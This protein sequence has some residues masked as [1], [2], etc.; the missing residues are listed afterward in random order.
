MKL[1]LMWLSAPDGSSESIGVNQP[2]SVEHRKS[3]CPRPTPLDVQLLVVKHFGLEWGLSMARRL[4]ALA[5]VSFLLAGCVVLPPTEQYDGISINRV[6]DRVKC[7]LGAA[8]SEEPILQSW[9]GVITLTL[10]VDH[11]GSVLPSTSL[12]GPFNA[13]TYGLD[14]SAGATGKSVQT[15]LVNVYFPV[16]ELL[17]FAEAC[18][19]APRNQLE[20]S[21]GL[22]EWVTRTL[23]LKTSEGAVFK[24][25]DK[26]IGYT[27]EFDLD[28]TAGITPG[29][30]FSRVSG[31]AGLS[32]NRRTVNTLQIALADAGISPPKRIPSYVR[33]P[34]RPKPGEGQPGEIKPAEVPLTG[35][36][37]KPPA[38]KTYRYE[39]RYVVRGGGNVSDDAKKR[40]DVIIQQLQLRNLRIRGF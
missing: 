16:Y 33:V 4:A 8:L 29:F 17:A 24:D 1:L 39:K 36:E 38:A 2:A 21:L 32:I 5:C 13:G 14:I 40:L 37:P 31:K 18:P 10:E 9:V 34:V 15:S 30:T 26:A 22:H 35:D 23:S 25:K 7:E 12:T 19:I 11:T 3:A 20:D 28:L 6:V 27:L